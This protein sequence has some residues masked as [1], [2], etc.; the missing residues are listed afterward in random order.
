MKT[1]IKNLPF[2]IFTGFASAAYAAGGAETEGFSLILVL[3]I[4]FGALIVVFQLFPGTMLFMSMIK[5][6]FSSVKEEASPT[7]T[8]S[9]RT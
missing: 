4:A 6:L 3:F 7:G 9:D 2:A 8:E 1:T 5:G